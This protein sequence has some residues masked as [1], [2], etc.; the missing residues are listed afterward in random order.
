VT[1]WVRE[2]TVTY[3]GDATRGLRIASSSD[4]AGFLARSGALSAQA[5]C[6]SFAVVYLD[7]RNRTLGWEVVGRGGVSSCPVEVGSVFRGALVAGA[8]GIVIAHN[9]P[10]GDPTPSAEDIALTERIVRAGDLLSVRVLDHVIV[11]SE[12]HFSFLDA[13]LLRPR[14]GG[15]S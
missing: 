15:A 4:T 1:A 8:V 13:G 14:S 6:E 9:H 10:S 2:A 7:G 3:R 11:A 5:A 12:G